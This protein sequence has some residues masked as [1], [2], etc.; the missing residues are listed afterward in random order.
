MSYQMAKR[1]PYQ[2]VIW[3]IPPILSAES[4]F[5]WPHPIP[6]F[7]MFKDPCLSL[8]VRPSTWETPNI[9]IWGMERC[10]ICLV[11]LIRS[12]SSISVSSIAAIGIAGSA[13]IAI[14]TRLPGQ[15]TA[16]SPMASSSKTNRW[17]PQCIRMCNINHLK[18]CIATT[19]HQEP[20]EKS[21]ASCKCVLFHR[22]ILKANCGEISQVLL[23]RFF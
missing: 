16:A 15:Q 21:T 12:I 7:K 9:H 6:W 22:G 13:G 8:L 2:V 17:N 23:W 10:A 3:K 14:A 5:V 20:P 19:T 11:T 18:K 4:R 1:K